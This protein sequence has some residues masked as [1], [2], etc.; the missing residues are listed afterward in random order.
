MLWVLS[1]E[2]RDSPFPFPRFIDLGEPRSRELRAPRLL[3]AG[4]AISRRPSGP[5][6][7]KRPRTRACAII[8][9]RQPK[10]RS[11]P[12]RPSPH[13]A[14]AAPPEKARPLRTAAAMTEVI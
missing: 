6:T 12:S 9:A 2:L 13:V 5:T 14:R 4:N 7:L 10:G 11:A 3:N 1:G 8:T